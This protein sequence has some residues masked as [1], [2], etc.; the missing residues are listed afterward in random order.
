[1]NTNKLTIVSP[2]NNEHMEL[3]DNFER[4]NNLPT[5]ATTA[6]LATRGQF[7]EEEYKEYLSKDNEISLT[8][9]TGQKQITDA[10][11][12]HASKDIK[13][14]NIYFAPLS[15]KKKRPI[16]DLAADYALNVLGMEE[17]FVSIKTTEKS[18]IDSLEQSFENLGE[19]D[20]YVTY[21]KEKESQAVS[22]NFTHLH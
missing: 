9:F 12:I 5:D 6:L 11:I 8:I 2:Y 22:S 7:T 14:C 13:T 10:C 1:M 21:L 3:L 4:D 18:L 19:E 16:I 17:V 15:Q 20:G